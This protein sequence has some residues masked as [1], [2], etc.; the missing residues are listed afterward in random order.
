MYSNFMVKQKVK[1]NALLNE[2][3]GINK[4]LQCNKE[5]KRKRRSHIHVIETFNLL[6]TDR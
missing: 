1:T 3:M 2:N 5:K 6:P 4:V